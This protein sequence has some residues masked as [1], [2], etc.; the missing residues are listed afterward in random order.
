MVH[1]WRH[2]ILPLPAQ[3]WAVGRDDVAGCWLGQVHVPEG[4]HGE[5]AGAW[6][7][8]QQQQALLMSAQI[9]PGE[10]KPNPDQH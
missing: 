9:M 10:A 8:Q 4:N 6:Q 7:Q 1:T 5:G 2:C 3:R